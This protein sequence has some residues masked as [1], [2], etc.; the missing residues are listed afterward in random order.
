[1]SEDTSILR[2]LPAGVVDSGFASVATF[3]VGLSA[4]NLLDDVDRG[5]YAIFFS[6]F[7]MGALLS[8]EFIFTPAE[9]EAVSYPVSERLSL[10][11][12]SLL[13]GVGPC[14]LGAAAAVL[15][16]AVTA[17]YA[18]PQLAA[19]LAVTTAIATVLSPMQDHVRRM[20]HIAGLSWTAAS[21]SIVQFL[22]VVV[23]VVWGI[24]ADVGVA[25]IPFGALAVANAVSLIVGLMLVRLK[26][27]SE[28]KVPLRFRALASKGVWFVLNAAAPA[29]M[30]FTVA[31]LIAW[32]AS[33]ED[34]GYAEAARVVA[35]PVLVL[36][37]GLKVVLYPRSVRAAMDRDLPSARRTNN[38][39]LVAVGLG[40]AAYLLLVGWDW[41][42]NPMA[43]IVPAAYVLTG[44]VALTIAAN[45][46]NAAWF[47]QSSELAG[48]GRERSLAGISWITSLVWL[49][50]AFTAGVTGA[51]ARSLGALAG[52]GVRYTA[53][54]R[55]LTSVYRSTD[56]GASSAA[57]ANGDPDD[58]NS[59]RGDGTTSGD[60]L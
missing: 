36:A 17:G 49:L 48:A 22:V 26:V 45:L 58:L 54:I 31:A 5:V 25:W 8:N 30:G 4:V 33:P 50:M 40:G 37:A 14:L 46:A 60:T 43:V 7:I 44:L 42:L 16:I 28:A 32:L 35:Q 38:T 10:V 55:V 3:I 2:R 23:C 6:A 1:M 29:V 9:V 11:P 24:A 20:F 12:Q 39:Y 53:Q 56:V 57:Q 34:L 41:V 18:E 13:L 51:Y 59:D 21:I 15:A 19:G 27:E 47:L 52:A